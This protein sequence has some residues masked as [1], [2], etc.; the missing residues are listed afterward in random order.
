MAVTAEHTL[1]R[2]GLNCP[3]AEPR[4]LKA[5]FLK[6]QIDTSSN[7]E[8]PLM[9]KTNSNFLILDSPNNLLPCVSDIWRGLG[10]QEEVSYAETSSSVQYF[11]TAY[12]PS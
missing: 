1:Q 5:T 12:L 7:T 3:K 10:T 2:P 6:Q 11:K 8:Y 4:S 9:I